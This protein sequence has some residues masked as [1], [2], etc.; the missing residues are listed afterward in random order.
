MHLL[1]AICAVEL[2]VYVDT[3]VSTKVWIAGERHLA[4][5]L[6]SLC[7]LNRVIKHEKV[8][9]P[10]CLCDGKHTENN[11]EVSSSCEGSS[12]MNKMNGFVV[13]RC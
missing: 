1:P 7:A 8:L 4:A 3:K 12:R 11:C 6:V 10:V 13:V 9:L 5:E 2:T